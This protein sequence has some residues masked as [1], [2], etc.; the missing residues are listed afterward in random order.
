VASGSSTPHSGIVTPPPRSSIQ[1][2][3]T[4]SPTRSRA[5]PLP[6]GVD[7]PEGSRSRAGSSVS[8][9]NVLEALDNSAWGESIR[10]SFSTNRPPSGRPPGPG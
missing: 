4:V 10:R 5:P 7:E 8:A 1:V 6:L 2:S 3:P 9:Q